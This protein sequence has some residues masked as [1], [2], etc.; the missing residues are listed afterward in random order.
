MQKISSIGPAGIGNLLW[1]HA[2][3]AGLA[4][5]YLMLALW[6]SHL[7]GVVVNGQ[8]AVVLF[9]DFLIKLPQMAFFVLFWRLL[10]LTYVDRVPDR[11][12]VLKVEVRAVLSDRDRMVGALIAIVL[13]AMVLIAF[14]KLKN[15]IPVLHPFSWD[16]TFME[17]DRLL[18]FG[19]LPH[20]YA[21][22][23]F[24][25]HYPIIFFTGVY[26]VWLFL[27]YMA[28]LIVCFLRPDN[29][30]RMQYLLAFLLTWAV[31]GNLMATLFS[32]AGP[33]YY[34]LLG[35][36]ETYSGLMERLNA[37][38]A[39]GAL[40]VVET[41]DLLWRFYSM[42]DSIN[43]ISAFPSMHVATSVLM[44]ILAFRLSRL[45]GIIMALFALAMQIGSV[46]LAWHYAVDGYVGAAIALLCWKAAGILV[47]RF[48]GFPAAAR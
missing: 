39:T 29:A 24:G 1:R 18:H 33:A 28:L 35:L 37:H 48:G 44:A 36:G 15:L 46:L 19:R 34:E 45:A 23:V 11:V 38:A 25:G 22:M 21:H 2:L 14:A 43:S 3:L 26:N 9:K 32:S 4:L 6:L 10:V 27:M 5:A 16:V 20:E 41:Q 7:N 17:L 30:V 13:M 47:R 42:K 31:G 40:S 12:A 8:L